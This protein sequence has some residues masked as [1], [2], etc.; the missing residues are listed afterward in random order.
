MKWSVRVCIA[1]WYQLFWGLYFPVDIVKHD[2]HISTILYALM[3]MV[4]VDW[5][6][7]SVRARVLQSQGWTGM[8]VPRENHQV[9]KKV[10]LPSTLTSSFRFLS[11]TVCVLCRMETVYFLT[12]HCVVI[13]SWQRER[14]VIWF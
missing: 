6:I 5:L 10:C 8:P 1:Y 12:F 11:R 7:V 4:L 2:C 3:L 13:S 14:L 9:A